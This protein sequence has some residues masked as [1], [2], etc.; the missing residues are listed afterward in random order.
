MI[1]PRNSRTVINYNGCRSNL[2]ALVR[3]LSIRSDI[4]DGYVVA[5]KIDTGLLPEVDATA[6]VQDSLA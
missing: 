2:P 4:D 6:H 3:G 1:G 5:L